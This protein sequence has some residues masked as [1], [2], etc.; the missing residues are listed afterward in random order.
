[1]G[2]R[3]RGGRKVRG[4]GESGRWGRDEKRRVREGR[5]RVRVEEDERGEKRREG[6]G[7]LIEAEEDR[8][9][10]GGRMEIR[11]VLQG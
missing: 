8:E 1:M 4:E 5:R 7:D 3:R 10:N 6:R 9:R 2:D 11:R